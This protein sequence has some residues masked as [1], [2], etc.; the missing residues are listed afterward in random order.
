MKLITEMNFETQA[1][2]LIEA[3]GGKK[4]YFIEGTFMQSNVPNR[5]KR[6]YPTKILSEA[7]KR[8]NES[9]VKK[10]RAL[11]ELGHPTG[12]TVNLERVSHLITSLK[13]N[14][15]DYVGRAKILDTPYGNIVK[16]MIDGGVQLGVSSRGIGSLNTPNHEGISEV[17]NDFQL[18]TVD[19]VADPSAPNAFVEGIMEGVEWA[20]ENGS[21]IQEAQENLNKAYASKKEDIKEERIQEAMLLTG[22]KNFFAKLL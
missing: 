9:F 7:V 17:K 1:D 6:N 15:N 2:V 21:F 3:K 8:Y 12:P 22:M 11:G 20:Y 4:N 19:I 18:S 16:N 13:E 10:N 14:G 5:N